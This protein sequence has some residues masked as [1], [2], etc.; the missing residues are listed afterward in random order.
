MQLIL[1]RH[2]WG[3]TAPWEEVFPRFRDLGYRG[4]EAAVPE[5]GQRDRFRSLLAA[6]GL[7]FVAQV[8]TGGN[9]VEDHVESLRRQV[10]EAA[11]LGPRL[12][13][14]HSGRDAWTEAEAGR[15]FEAALRIEAAAGV[16]VAHETHRGRILFSPWVTARLLRQFPG[17]RLCCDF[18]HWVCVAERLIDDQLEILRDCAGR[19]AHLHARVG[20]EQGPQVSDPRAP[21][22]AAHLAAHERWWQLVWSAQRARGEVETTLTPEFGP[23][24]YLP[25]LPF[26]RV[27]VSDLWGICDWMADRQAARF[28]EWQRDAGGGG[29]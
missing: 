4:V 19:C 28:A 23:P 15:F 2:L 6:H 22:F 16:T 17:L 1:I 29:P 24:G 5:P 18:S 14:A 13:N 27:P 7:G 10:G 8:F 25:T 3:V 21:E 12:V 20:H 9:R 26:T 11:E